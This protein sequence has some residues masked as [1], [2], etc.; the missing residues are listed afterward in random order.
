MPCNPSTKIEPDSRGLVPAT[1]AEV[2]RPN[3]CCGMS[4]AW[5]AAEPVLS[6]AAGGVEGSAAMTVEEAAD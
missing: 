2:L 1:H 3:S 4:T 6:D 5:M